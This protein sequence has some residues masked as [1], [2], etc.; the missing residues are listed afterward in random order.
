MTEIE[1]RISGVGSD[2]STNGAKT[3]AHASL[4]FIIILPSITS[5]MLHVSLESI[6]IVKMMFLLFTIHERARALNLSF[7]YLQDF[8]LD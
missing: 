7:L 1:P 5:W 6:R 8:Q 3:T 2:R 4:V